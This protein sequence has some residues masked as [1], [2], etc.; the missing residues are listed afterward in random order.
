MLFS[1]NRK[2]HDVFDRQTKM[3]KGCRTMA[4]D[5][6]NLLGKGILDKSSRD[7]AI[8]ELS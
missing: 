6:E 1:G 4:E 2:G 3:P 7:K 8:E 5:I